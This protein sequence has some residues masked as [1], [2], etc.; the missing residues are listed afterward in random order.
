MTYHIF[1]TKRFEKS[2]AQIVRSGKF[3]RRDVEEVLATLA[4][5]HS[6]P[7][8]YRDH[9]LKGDLSDRREC[10]VRGDILLIY[11]KDNDV[12]VLLDLDIGTHHELFGS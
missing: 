7:A 1:S 8:S 11:R 6:L 5:G 3:K 10:H 2:L 4:S 9:A 12:L